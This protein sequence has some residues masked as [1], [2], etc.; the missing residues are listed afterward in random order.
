MDFGYNVTIDQN[1]QVHNIMIIIDLNGLWL[2]R[3]NR[4]EWAGT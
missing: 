4:L 3:N 2:Q 1:G